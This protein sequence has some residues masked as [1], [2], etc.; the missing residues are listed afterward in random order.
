[1]RG[2]ATR[3]WATASSALAVSARSRL[4]DVCASASKEAFSM[5]ACSASRAFSSAS[6]SAAEALTMASRCSRRTSCRSNLE[7]ACAIF[8]SAAVNAA[9]TASR[10]ATAV[11]SLTLSSSISASFFAFSFSKSSRR[12]ASPEVWASM[13]FSILSNSSATWA[14]SRSTWALSIDNRSASA[15]TRRAA[16]SRRCFASVDA[17]KTASRCAA[18]KDESHVVKSSTARLRS[19]RF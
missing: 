7:R 8:S 15:A 2:E 5:A 16:A 9:S 18:S 3:A 1:M 10:S 6:Q 13:S 14:A 11:L 12:E 17:V 4:W 19:F